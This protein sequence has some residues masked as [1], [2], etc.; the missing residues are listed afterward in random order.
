MASGPTLDMTSFAAALKKYYTD[1]R[2]RN[3]VYTN[4]PALGLLPK[5]RDFR[6]KSFEVPITIG[7][8]QGRSKTF[9]S[10]L[11]NKHASEHRRFSIPHTKNYALA[12]IDGLT[13]QASIGDRGAFMEAA[14]SE[15]DMALQSL[16]NDLAGD[17]YRDG[18]GVR[19]QV[20]SIS[21]ND[22]TLSDPEDI[23]HFELGMTLEG[24]ANAGG[25]KGAIYAAEQYVVTAVDRDAGI[26]TVDTVG[27]L[28]ATDYLAQEG[29]GSNASARP[30]KLT[31]FDGWLPDPS[32]ILPAD[33][34]FGVN[35]SE[36]KTRL[37]GVFYDAT[38]PGDNVEAA[39]VNAGAKL[40]REGGRPDVVLMHPTRVAELD[41]LLEQRG[42]YEK[43]DSSDA[44]VGFESIA[45]HTGGGTVRVIAD[46]WAP[47]DIC[48]ML[49]L[50]TW[51]L[52]S[53]GEA[54]KLLTHDGNR[55]LRTAGDDAVEVRA[56]FYANLACSAPGKNCRIKLA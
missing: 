7:V 39:L 17:L 4:R 37:G 12:N 9:S 41:R 35:R 24:I 46:P 55:L 10:A 47:K 50:D 30:D 51:K 36:D 45:V 11:A 42:R 18:S 8:P 1:D 44:E 6:G 38:I 13:M 2:V 34:H 31:G 21:V 33:S 54:P 22:I 40:F 56:G 28:V 49:Q 53:I 26:I 23:V 14:T 29:D 20:G 25:K 19:G 43:T 5:K 16:A 52:C 48:F 3:M 15:I 32:L 27:S